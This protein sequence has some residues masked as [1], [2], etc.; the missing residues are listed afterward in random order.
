MS[1]DKLILTGGQAETTQSASRMT[2]EQ[3]SLQFT[4]K[5]QEL[6]SM[7]KHGQLHRL[8]LLEG[9]VRSGKTWISLILWQA[10]IAEQ[11]KNRFYL[12][13]G[14]TLQTLKRNCLLPLQELIGENNFDF[15]LSAKEGKMFGRTI[16]LE[17]ANDA[18]SEYK[19]RGITLGGAYAD[20]LTLYPEDFFTML[21][22]RLSETGAKLIATTNPD[23]PGHWLKKKYIDVP[24]INMLCIKFLIGD[25][26]TLDP[27]Y[28]SSIKRE[29]QGVFY[30]RFILGRWVTA[31]GAIYTTFANDPKHF[32]ISVPPSDLAIVT[33]GFDFGGNGSAHAGVCTGITRGYQQ[34]VT[35][36]EYYRKQVISP[37][38]LIT[39]ICDFIVRCQRKYK[40]FD[41]YFDSAETT[42]IE[43]VRRAVSKRKIK[44]NIRNARKGAILD[45]IRF[46]QMLQ[47]T[48][49]YRI[50]DCCPHT[51]E[52]FSSAV[53]KKTKDG[54]D[55]RLDDGT[56]NI[57]NLDAQ[58]YS[59]ET[60][61]EIIGRVENYNY[62]G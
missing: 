3:S 14:K 37:E 11:P 15:S 1:D 57:D 12:M 45:R 2:H 38:T 51:I 33:I 10:W 56:V 44:C 9:S 6:M 16:M 8:N 48:D 59:T 7:F 58:E 34:V 5:Q 54:S 55:E 4:A 43:G 61:Q 47:G 31:E 13:T 46:Y 41:A 20:E 18:K 36:D 19:I 24:D 26:T 39:D 42:L 40:V 50:L 25:N 29:Y 23:N 22:S 21:L 35:L 49:R 53:W 52:A 30:D 62:G 32:I 27:E 60:Y 17:G 28:V